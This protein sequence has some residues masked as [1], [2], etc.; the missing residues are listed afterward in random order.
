MDNFDKDDKTYQDLQAVGIEPDEI[1]SFSVEGVTDYI[2][3][4]YYENR[5]AQGYSVPEEFT[6][7]GVSRKERELKYQA[8]LMF[9]LEGERTNRIPD[10]FP[11]RHEIDYDDDELVYDPVAK[12]WIPDWMFDSRERDRADEERTR[13]KIESLEPEIE[14]IQDAY[15]ASVIRKLKLARARRKAREKRLVKA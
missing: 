7:Q 1:E 11:N 9:D 10:G 5:L 8:M 4:E 6:E 15:M 2:V 13:L 14:K 3:R 12:E